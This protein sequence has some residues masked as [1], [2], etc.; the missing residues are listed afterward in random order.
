MA[1]EI[2]VSRVNHV[3]I[4][5]TDRKK[6]L[7]FWRDVLGVKVI[8]SMVDSKNIVWTAVGDGTMVHLI[9]PRDGRPAGYHTAFEVTNFDA[10]LQ[11][12]RDLGLEIEGPGERHDGQRYLFIRDPDGNRIEFVTSSNIKPSRRV[13]DELGYTR[14]P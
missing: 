4:P 1:G 8:P 10:T 6:A 2:H 5:I 9:E 11:R 14:E 7:A 3:G 13:A 12:F